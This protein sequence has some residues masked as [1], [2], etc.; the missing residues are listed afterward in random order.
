[1]NIRLRSFNGFINLADITHSWV[2]ANPEFS[3]YDGDLQVGRLECTPSKVHVEVLDVRYHDYL[4]AIAE[5][6]MVSYPIVD[7][8]F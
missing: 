5:D 8:K 3:V 1:M 4:D 2:L 6:I 7:L